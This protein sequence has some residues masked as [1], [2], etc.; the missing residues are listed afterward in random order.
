ME[1]ESYSVTGTDTYVEAWSTTRLPFE[2]KGWLLE[3]RSD[4]RRALRAGLAPNLWTRGVLDYAASG[5]VAA[6]VFS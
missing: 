3:Y 5:M 6:S 1:Q 2:P 4:L